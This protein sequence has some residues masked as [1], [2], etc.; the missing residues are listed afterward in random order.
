MRILPRKPLRW[1][2]LLFTIG[3]LAIAFRSL[4]ATPEI[5]PGTYLMIDVSGEFAVA[6]PGNALHQLVDDR[7]VLSSLIGALDR[8]R[9]DDRIAGAV[10]RI[11]GLDM[12]WGR[13]REIRD[14]IGRLRASNKSVV[15]FLD[16]ATMGANK[17]Y[18]LATAADEIFVPPAGAPMLTGLSAR[19]VFF[20][21]L[22]GHLNMGVQ[23][24][25]I[26][27]FKGFGDQI[28]G[29]GMT[30][31][32]R[33]MGN[34]ILDDLNGE[35]IGSI[36]E[37]RGMGLE[38]VQAIVDSCPATAA[39]FVEAGLADDQLFL[40]Q[41]LLD[42]G[43]GEP[44]AT[45]RLAQYNREQIVGVFSKDQPKVAVIYAN[46]TIVAGKS[47]GRS[48]LSDSSVGSYTLTKA[49]QKAADDPEI[50][51]IVFR[52]NSPGGSPLGSDHVWRAARV[53][54]EKK[55]V[56]ASFSDVAASGGYYMAAAADLVVAEP[57]TLTGSIGVV[58]IR[59]NI[60]D[61]LA[62]FEIGTE[63]IDRGRYSSI[64]DTSRPMNE[65]EVA[66]VREQMASTYRLFLDRVAVG[67]DM[68]VEEVDAL[69]GGRV[70]T[71]QQALDRG[72]VDKLGGMDD[73]I[74][75]AAT[76]AGLPDPD[77]ISMVYLPERRP[78]LQELLSPLTASSAT[79]YLPQG[80]R[81]VVEGLAIYAPLDSGVQALSSAVFHIQ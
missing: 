53:A 55:P 24:E 31:P 38:E 35:F 28:G 37:A 57:T 7:R 27:E 19:Y 42:L 26:R 76:E 23:V 12:G 67:R 4:F 9:S 18:Y 29:R 60:T 68:T 71:G 64:D 21:G 61:L 51:A 36:A 41:I 56:I 10:L 73:A 13:L 52:V 15:A 69:G 58:L 74:R 50:K 3:T 34:S 40:D 75:L 33:E 46:G 20:G 80:L 8:A 63:A 11:H 45:V 70:W 62:R 43:D 54:A 81:E 44:V 65:A 30:E 32:L 14:A 48:P 2:F 1:L 6:P 59:P 5:E 72:L 77:N 25:K 78:F 66:L 39:D 16:T 79:S 47:S 22:W 49:F 17:E